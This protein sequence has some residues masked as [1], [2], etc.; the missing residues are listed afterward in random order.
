MI[1]LCF[2]CSS[3]EFVYD[4]MMELRKAGVH[5]PFVWH[6]KEGPQL[7]MRFGTWPKLME[8][9]ELSA[10]NIITNRR[11]KEWYDL[12]LPTGKPYLIL[13]QEMPKKNI[14]RDRFRLK[15]RLQT[16]KSIRWL[17]DG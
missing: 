7:C 5:V 2:C 12:F 1:Y 15:S 16:G 10:G 8:L 14:L 9:Y 11:T 17:S 4:S 13:D 3:L 6:L